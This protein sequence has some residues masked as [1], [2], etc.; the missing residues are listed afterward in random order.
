[1]WDWVWYPVHDSV[2]CGVRVVVDP[3]AIDSHCP[4]EERAF[5]Y[6][7]TTTNTIGH[8]G[9]SAC[10]LHE[11]GEEF[12]LLFGGLCAAA[13]AEPILSPR[14]CANVTKIRVK[15]LLASMQV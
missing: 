6:N 10:V 3:T 14:A 7:S 11:E 2:C 9:E 12:V 13:A 4:P 1:M 15:S 8:S 5:F